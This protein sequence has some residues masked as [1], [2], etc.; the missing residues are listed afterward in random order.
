[1]ILDGSANIID[2]RDKITQRVYYA[3]SRDRIDHF[4]ERL[5]GWWFG[6]VIK[7]LASSAPEAILVLA[8]DQ[9]VD[10]LREEFKRSALPVD[11]GSTLPR[12]MLSLNSINGLSFDSFVRLRSVLDASSM[13]SVTTIAPPNSVPGGHVKSY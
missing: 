2:L 1:M 8:I 10:E 3:A 7:A 9:R 11:Y 4:V 5:E 6:V 13:P 12:K